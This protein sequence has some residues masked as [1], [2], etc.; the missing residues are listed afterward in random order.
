[1][2]LRTLH[3]VPRGT[4]AHMVGV[5]Q[6]GKQVAAGEGAVAEGPQRRS[7]SQVRGGGW[8]PARGCL[9]GKAAAGVSAGAQDDGGGRRRRRL[10]S[11]ATTA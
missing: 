3:F 9:V 8:G 5:A 6:G 4:V 7:P 10:W 11:W 1:M 2:D